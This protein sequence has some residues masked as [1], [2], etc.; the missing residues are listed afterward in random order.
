MNR[1]VLQERL[2]RVRRHIAMGEEN[3]A[4]LRE[5]IARLERSGHDSSAARE[6]LARFEE[7][8]KLPVADRDRLEMELA[9]PPK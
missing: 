6:L 8:Q 5:I 3:L 1:S 2:N 4:R 7:L 9:R